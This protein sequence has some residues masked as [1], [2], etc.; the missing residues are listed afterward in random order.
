M[1]TDSGPDRP[2]VEQFL[3]TAYVAHNY[4]R[5]NIGWPSEVGQITATEAMA[6]HKKYYVGVK[7]GGGRSLAM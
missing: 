7:R 3:A 5:S 1:R 2:M 6:F 4:G